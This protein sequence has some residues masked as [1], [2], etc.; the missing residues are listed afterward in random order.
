MSKKKIYALDFK[1][2]M[3]FNKKNL[4]VF[5]KYGKAILYLCISY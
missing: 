1:N 3:G 2:I 4:R 5:F